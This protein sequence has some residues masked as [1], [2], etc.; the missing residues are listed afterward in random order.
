MEIQKY[1]IHKYKIHKYKLQD[2]Y[3]ASSRGEEEA[4]FPGGETK[5]STGQHK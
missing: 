5:V 1:K 2:E 4:K 3:L